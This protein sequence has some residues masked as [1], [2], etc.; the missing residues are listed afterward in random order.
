V[1]IVMCMK[2]GEG[3]VRYGMSMGDEKYTR[4]G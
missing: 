4:V 2:V 3:E 1:D